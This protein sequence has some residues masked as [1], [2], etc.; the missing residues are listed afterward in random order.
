MD[1]SSCSSRVTTSV[2]VV[3]GGRRLTLIGPGYWQGTPRRTHLL[4]GEPL[5]HRTLR[6]W[7]RRH[8]RSTLYRRLLSFI[9]AGRGKTQDRGMTDTDHKKP[10]ASFNIQNDIQVTHRARNLG[11]KM[12]RVKFGRSGSGQDRAVCQS[13]WILGGGIQVG[14]FEILQIDGFHFG[15]L[16]TRLLTCIRGVRARF[17]LIEF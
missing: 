2:T 3:L 13:R 5:S 11:Q 4:Q 8:E 15:L 1:R 16:L 9:G 6:S 14:L 10:S 17:S 7:Q 12:K